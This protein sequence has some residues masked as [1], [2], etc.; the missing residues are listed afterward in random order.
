MT[1]TSSYRLV[2]RPN[3]SWFRID[4]QSV[5]EYRDLLLLLVRRDFVS[6]YTQTVLG[7][8]WFVLQ[9]L[10]TTAVFAVIFG[11]LAHL[12]TDGVPPVLFYLCG[13]TGW[14]YFSQSVSS[15]SS[16]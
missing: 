3:R 7:P 2:I 9:P 6:K 14:S 15:T 10:L 5:W 8:A 4:W 13:L 12:S 1:A 11:G 16:T